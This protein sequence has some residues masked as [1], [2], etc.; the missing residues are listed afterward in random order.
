MALEY[1]APDILENK[2]IMEWIIFYLIPI[3][4]DLLQAGKKKI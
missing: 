3:Y 1:N 2:S 4:M